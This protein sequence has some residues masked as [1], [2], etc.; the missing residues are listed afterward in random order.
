MGK[1]PTARRAPANLPS[2]KSESLASSPSV[3]SEAAAT[4]ASTGV[5]TSSSAGAPVVSG[6]TSAASSSSATANK[7][8]WSK[9]GDARLSNNNDGKDANGGPAPNWGAK[10]TSPLFSRDFPSLQDDNALKKLDGNADGSALRPKQKPPA[11]GGHN[12]KRYG[13]GPNLRPQSSRTWLHGG[14]GPKPGAPSGPELGSPDLPARTT[15]L[16]PSSGMT[17]KEKI[18]SKTPV[19]LSSLTG[20]H[21][22]KKAN[23][24]KRSQ[25]PTFHV[26]KPR[27]TTANPNSSASQP[28]RESFSQNSI[29]DNEKLKR[30]DF[31]ES[32]DDD[33]AKSDDNFDYNK[34]ITRYVQS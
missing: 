32:A 3:P 1:I 34:K 25:N 23:S 12:D 6:A 14:A 13:P 31:T 18:D 11:V 17:F 20:G 15:Q 8:L 9:D 16:A 7:P 29:I 24:D 26:P 5:A 30:M 33:W 19:F 10:T 28:S 22:G 21:P 27:S 2:L 4:S